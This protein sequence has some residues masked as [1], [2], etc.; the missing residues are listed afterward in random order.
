[1]ISVLKKVTPKVA[2]IF[3]AVNVPDSQDIIRE[4]HLYNLLLRKPGG[5]SMRPEA[6]FS[7]K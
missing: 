1:M 4:S 3:Y 6:L 7:V 5:A 2:F